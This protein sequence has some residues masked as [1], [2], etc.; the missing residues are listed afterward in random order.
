MALLGDYQPAMLT[1]SFGHLKSK[2]GKHQ[3]AQDQIGW[4]QFIASVRI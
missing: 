2:V 4:R 1:N 3:L